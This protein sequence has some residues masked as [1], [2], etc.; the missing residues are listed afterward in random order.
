VTFK[1]LRK[2]IA[3]NQKLDDDKIAI[4]RA[5]M[6]LKLWPAKSG[7]GHN[8]NNNNINWEWKGRLIISSVEWERLAGYT[9]FN[10]H[11]T[12]EEKYLLKI[13]LDVDE[14]VLPKELLDR[15]ESQTRREINPRALEYFP[16]GYV[17]VIF[18]SSYSCPN[19]PDLYKMWVSDY[20]ELLIARGCESLIPTDKP[21]P[22]FTPPGK[23]S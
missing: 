3:E 18:Y 17:R 6:R 7:N 19:A 14:D 21:Y 9:E 5:I 15:V 16:Y 10:D 1:D 23:L 22:H 12:P 11:L 4:M 2:I 20:R 8:K 13:S